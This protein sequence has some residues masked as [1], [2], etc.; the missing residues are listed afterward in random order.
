MPV[1]TKLG[2][3]WKQDYWQVNAVVTILQTKTTNS[4]FGASKDT[5]VE[6]NIRT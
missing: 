2:T 3:S 1:D 4:L 5:I 6:Q